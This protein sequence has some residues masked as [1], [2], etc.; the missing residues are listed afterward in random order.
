VDRVVE[1]AGKITADDVTVDLTA[2]GCVVKRLLESV[3]AVGLLV[4][5]RVVDEAVGR[6]VERV[7]ISDGTL[8]VLRLMVAVLVDERTAETFAEPAT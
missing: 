4:V 6:V 7:V 5:G 8:V 2:A 3:A 1:R